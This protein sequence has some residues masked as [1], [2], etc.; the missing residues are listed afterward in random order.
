MI[1]RFAARASFVLTHQDPKEALDLYEETAAL[2]QTQSE[3]ELNTQG[4]QIDWN[5]IVNNLL[6]CFKGTK[7]CVLKTLNSKEALRMGEILPIL[8]KNEQVCI[9]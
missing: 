7:P 8:K 4:F 9:L 5:L 3:I 6:I 1:Q 2:P